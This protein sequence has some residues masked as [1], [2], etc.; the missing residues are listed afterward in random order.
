MLEGHE[1]AVI[2]ETLSRCRLFG[3]MTD[4]VRVD[5]AQHCRLRECE[6]GEW[7]CREGEVGEELFVLSRGVVEVFIT[8]ADGAAGG[9]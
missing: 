6:P 8:T 4:G 7:L 5:L 1:R 9:V 3:G 2:A